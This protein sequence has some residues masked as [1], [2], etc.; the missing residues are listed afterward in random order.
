MNFEPKSTNQTPIHNPIPK[1]ESP[2]DSNCK[3]E[4]RVV[5]KNSKVRASAVKQSMP[6]MVSLKAPLPDDIVNAVKNSNKP[7]IDLICLLDTSGSMDGDK[8][9][10]LKKTFSYLFQY[11]TSEDRVGIITFSSQAFELCPL[12]CASEKNKT[13]MLAKIEGLSAEGGTNITKGI[14]LA[15][16]KLSARK[17]NND[18][19]SIFLLSDGL[20]DRAKSGVKSLVD[21]YAEK[22][23]CADYTIH[24]FGYGDDHDSE[25]MSGISDLRDGNFYYIQVLDKIDEC[26][27]ECLGG[28]V[29][30]VAKHVE[31]RICPVTSEVF[32]S[33]VKLTK[34]F[35]S[36]GMWTRSKEGD[37]VT[38][39]TQLIAGKSKDYVL[40]LE[41]PGIEEGRGP[42]QGFPCEARVLQAYLTFYDLQ[43]NLWTDI[44]SLELEV[45]ATEDSDFPL[46]PDNR[47]LLKNLVRVRAAEVMLEAKKAADQNDF[48]W[49]CAIIDTFAEELR[50]TEIKEDD[51]VVAIAKDLEKMRLQLKPST[52]HSVGTHLL[53]ENIKANSQ[54]KGA[55][56]SHVSYSSPMQLQMVTQVSSKKSTSTPPTNKNQ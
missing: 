16:S 45:F 20:D 23:Q 32:S 39:I 29:T 33:D 36:P 22:K 18:I 49:G 12:A 2:R 10:T 1:M 26:F 19:T 9:T 13:E 56:N 43:D 48:K 31:I 35:G 14:E 28:L 52:Y 8:L 15:L 3:F 53:S 46:V 24:A 11:L 7:T 27:V 5:A 50:E 25:L 41:L 47:E 4:F 30:T 51:F 42:G 40:D 44:A 55:L 37:Y 34:A 21:L 6:I 17:Q 38:H 54:Q